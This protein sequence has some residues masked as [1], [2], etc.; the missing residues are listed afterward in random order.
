MESPPPVQTG[1]GGPQPPSSPPGLG[2]TEV[3]LGVITTSS[4]LEQGNKKPVS[5]RIAYICQDCGYVY[6][7][8]TPFEDLSESFNC[9]GKALFFS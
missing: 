8:E 6:D 1:K 2:G 4:P 7:Q 5:E 9:P 3:P